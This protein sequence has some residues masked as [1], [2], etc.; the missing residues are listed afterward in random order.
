M[1]TGKV[2]RCTTS[3]L[4]TDCRSNSVLYETGLVLPRKGAIRKLIR[5]S[6]MT[7]AGRIADI[8]RAPDRAVLRQAVFPE[9]AAEGGDILF[10]GTQAYTREYPALLETGGGICWTIDCDPTVARFGAQQRHIV[11]SIIDLGR[12]LPDVRFKTIVLAGVFGFGVNRRSEQIAAL[13]ACANALEPNGF[14]ILSWNDRRVP[15]T[16]LEEAASRWFDYRSFGHLPS[17]LWVKGCDQNF[18]FFRRSADRINRVRKDQSAPTDRSLRTGA[19]IMAA[20][21]AMM[22]IA[23]SA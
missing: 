9:V 16:V 1:V 8:A 18:A 22:S 12:H 20:M 14:L 5:R 17:R 15:A 6:M 7:S 23:T 21:P 3:D 4:W 11:G 13:E 19:S 2:E 10:V